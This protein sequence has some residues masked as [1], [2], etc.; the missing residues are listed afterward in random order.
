MHVTNCYTQQFNWTIIHCPWTASLNLLLLFLCPY[1]IYRRHV[2][3][4]SRTA[5]STILHPVKTTSNGNSFSSAPCTSATSRNQICNDDLR[6]QN[7]RTKQPSNIVYKCCP[8]WEQMYKHSRG[9]NKRECNRTW[10][11]ILIYY[12][13][14]LP[15]PNSLAMIN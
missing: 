13:V 12:Q 11:A 15:D 7:R 4:E 9:C 2:C 10:R 14:P 6:Q 5:T 1:S 3:V 8:G